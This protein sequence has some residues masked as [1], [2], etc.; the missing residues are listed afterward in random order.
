MEGQNTER[1]AD[2]ELG[3]PFDS[4]FPNGFAGQDVMAEIAPEGWQRSPL[5]ACFHPSVER[6][7]EEEV[8]M[9][10]HLESLPWM[11]VPRDGQTRTALP[12]HT[13]A[14]VQ[15]EYKRAPVNQAEQVTE[16]V[17][18][19]LWDIFSDNHEVIMADGRCADIGSFRGASAFLDEYLTRGH[20]GWCEGDY[21]RFYMGSIFMSGRADLT[22]VYTM[23][24]RRLLAAGRRLDLS[25]SGAR[26]R[27]PRAHSGR[28]GAG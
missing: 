28:T 2:S 26:D 24:F 1:L 20:E 22:P 6:I 11:K 5:V 12:E 7:F 9:R 27:R 16:L 15:R 19:C 21:M 17:G 23:I 4:L 25:L 18:M 8:R 10:R 3:S 14:E 13:L